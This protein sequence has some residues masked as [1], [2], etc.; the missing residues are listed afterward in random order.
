VRAESV[1]FP[2]TDPQKEG[3]LK[4]M[5]KPT[6]GA[7]AGIEAAKMKLTVVKTFGA[8]KFFHAANDYIF[9]NNTRFYACRKDYSANQHANLCVLREEATIMRA[10]DTFNHTPKLVGV[11]AV[12][13]RYPGASVIINGNMTFDKVA[14]GSRYLTKRCHG[15]LVSGSVY[16]TAT[17]SDNDDENVPLIDN[18]FNRLGGS[19]LAGDTAKYVAMVADHKF[20]FKKGRVP[21]A[22]G[23]P[24]EALGGLSTNYAADNPRP[25]IG[26]APISETKNMI[27]TVTPDITTSGITGSVVDDAK[28]SGVEA[29]PGGGAGELK[30]LMLDGGSSNALAYITPNNSHH[31]PV[32]GTKHTGDRNELVPYY[33][34]CIHTY[35][36]FQANPPRQ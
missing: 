18:P 28:K 35:V 14:E 19:E 22:A 20:E 30:L 29:L 24:K 4:L 25:F 11:D 6:G 32:K 17:S 33:D 3:D 10:L 2:I 9:E 5:I 21:V 16:N 1:M 8:K 23:I 31:I 12:S 34:Y 27:F 36:M 26:E 13:G 15:R 7:A